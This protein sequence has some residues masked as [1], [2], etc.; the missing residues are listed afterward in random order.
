MYQEKDVTIDDFVDVI[1]GGAVLPEKSVPFSIDTDASA[2]DV[3]IDILH[4]GMKMLFADTAGRIRVS[5][6]SESEVSGLIARF[7]SMSV[8]LSFSQDHSLHTQSYIE[9]TGDLEN[10]FMVLHDRETGYNYK[11]TFDLLS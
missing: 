10:S 5:S 6:L 11:V 2:F 9:S 1:F 3:L 8:S 4:S 7:R